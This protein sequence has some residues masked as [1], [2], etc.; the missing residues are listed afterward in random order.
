MQYFVDPIVVIDTETT[1]VTFAAELIEL[2]AVC[3]DEWGNLRSSF[4]TLV[5]PT[6]TITNRAREAL[7]VNNITE[8]E[9]AFAPSPSICR[10]QF[11]SWYNS[12]PYRIAPPRTLAYN[13][14]F[15][16]RMLDQLG[17]QLNWGRCLKTLTHKIT[18]D[19]GVIFY[20]PSGK[21]KPPNL[22]EACSFFEI[23]Y[24]ENAHRALADTEVTAQIALKIAHNFPLLLS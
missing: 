5:H 16:K 1:G 20:G 23:P 6:K 9:L 14:Q 19:A 22:K 15:D 7:N 21:A 10:E 17:V 12:I 8:D 4:S 18:K 2:A 3:L 11:S 24:P 13:V